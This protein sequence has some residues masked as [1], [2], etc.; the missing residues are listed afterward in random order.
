[1][2]WPFCIK[3]ATS[4]YIKLPKSKQTHLTRLDIEFKCKT[5]QIIPA[6]SPLPRS[7]WPE[8]WVHTC[9]CVFSAE[10]PSIRLKQ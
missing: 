1:M 8:T 5:L 4:K 9:V 10:R 6:K 2:I 3:G 7:F